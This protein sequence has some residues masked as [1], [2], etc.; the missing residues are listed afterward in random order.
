MLPTVDRGF[1]PNEFMDIFKINWKYIE[2]ISELAPTQPL[3]NLQFYPLV[4]ANFE[5][6]KKEK[7]KETIN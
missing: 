7:V 2:N 6:R 4:G 5:N 3:Q 1:A